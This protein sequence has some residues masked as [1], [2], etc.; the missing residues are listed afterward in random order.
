MLSAIPRLGS[1]K[2]IDVIWV[3]N[4]SSLISI[5]QFLPVGHSPPQPDPGMFLVGGDDGFHGLP[6]VARS[7]SIEVFERQAVLEKGICDHVNTV[8]QN[9]GARDLEE[10]PSCSVKELDKIT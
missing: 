9:P 5:P 2:A 8:Y 1:A 10:Q 7:Q 6:L 3:N 4:S